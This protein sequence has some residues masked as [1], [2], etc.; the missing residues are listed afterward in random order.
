MITDR[1]LHCNKQINTLSNH[2]GLH[3]HCF[4]EIFQCTTANN[5]SN[6]S[7]RQFSSDR[8]T[9][10]NIYL[11]SYFAGNYRK[12][13]ASLNTHRYILKFQETNMPHLVTV[14]FIINKLAKQF[15]LPIPEPFAII[16]INNELSFVEKNFLD[17]KKNTHHNL[18][19]IYHYLKK[20][21][22]HYTVSNIYNAILNETQ[23]YKDCE[24]FLET[25]LFDALIGND[26]RHGRNLAILQTSKEKKLS[27]IYDNV[28]ALGRESGEWLKAHWNP[29]GKILT[30]FSSKPSIADYVKEIKKLGHANTLDSFYTKLLRVNTTEIINSTSHLH[31]EMKQALIKLIDEKK[32]GF[33]CEYTAT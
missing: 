5:F 12:Y 25:L 21:E 13:D 26:D 15:N 9:E 18:I 10:T 31:L 29:T 23:S 17:N 20:G 22:Q 30:K 6:L 14:E 4:D 27:P 16:K 33:I 3:P 8:T 11:S 28:S 19:H 32:Q 2:Y 1:C 7:E 24:I